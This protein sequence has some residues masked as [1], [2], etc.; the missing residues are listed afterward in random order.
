M[1]PADPKWLPGW[2]LDLLTH[3]EERGERP[4]QLGALGNGLEHSSQSRD[5]P[6]WITS[7]SQSAIKDLTHLWLKDENKVTKQVGAGMRPG[8]VRVTQYNPSISSMVGDQG[9]KLRP[10]VFPF[11]IAV[12][13]W[14]RLSEY[15]L[16][17]TDLWN[18][19]SSPYISSSYAFRRIPFGGP[20]GLPSDTEGTQSF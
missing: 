16:L 20:L 7:T 8:T 11:P 1:L 5:H 4:H 14:S 12:A 2:R 10:S 13:C 9:W 18:E 15:S 6:A 17:C 19:I 3:R